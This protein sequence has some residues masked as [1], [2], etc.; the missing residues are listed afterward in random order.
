MA[1]ILFGLIALTVVC[2]LLSYVFWQD[3][4]SYGGLDQYDHD[5]AVR[6]AL[7]FFL[8]AITAAVIAA[9]VY[10]WIGL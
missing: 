9:V 8:G 4:K 10:F 1:V 2:F 6:L 7:G 5:L 3:S